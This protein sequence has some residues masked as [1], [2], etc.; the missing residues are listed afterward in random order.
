MNKNITIGKIL[1]PHGVKGLF[2][3]ISYAQNPKDIFN[4]KTYDDSEVLIKLE[5][6][7]M[8]SKAKNGDIFIAA[9]KGVSDR[10]EI[11]KFTNKEIFVH[12]SSL[13]S[14]EEGEYYFSD[15]EGLKTFNHDYK[16]IGKIITVNDFGAGP[17]LEVEFIEKNKSSQFFPFNNDCV[18]EVNLDQNF[19]K[20]N[21]KNYE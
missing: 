15:L 5:F 20:L 2:H 21:T 13:P 11:A 14:P 7:R 8:S 12:R 18:I 1:S 9:I 19:I 4:Y 6:I 17:L 10:N 16:E 3:L